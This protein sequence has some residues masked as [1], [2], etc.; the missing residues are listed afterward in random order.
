MR[1]LLLLIA[2]LL[3][4]PLSGCGGGTSPD[5][6]D[7]EEALHKVAVADMPALSDC[8][9]RISTHLNT[10]GGQEQLG[11]SCAVGT[12]SGRSTG[13]YDCSLKVDVAPA[14]LRLSIQDREISIPLGP[15]AYSADGR[16]LMNVEDASLPGQPGFQAVRYVAGSADEALTETL[17]LRLGGGTPRLPKMI[18]QSVRNNQ[19]QTTVCN[20]GR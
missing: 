18:Y 6:R 19:A 2:L 10:T 7:S 12:Y 20:F 11:I 5:Q 8:L 1:F 13:G 17:T 15:T 3:V 4:S 9:Q 16:P 14:E